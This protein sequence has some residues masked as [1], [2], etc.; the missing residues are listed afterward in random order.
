MVQLR[1][2]RYRRADQSR[3][4]SRFELNDHYGL[5]QQVLNLDF[6]PQT[7]WM[8]VGFWKNNPRSLPQACQALLEEVLRE[9][10]LDARSDDQHF[11]VLEVGCGCAEP[12]RFLRQEFPA[13]FD[14]YIG[15]TLNACQADYAAKR[16]AADSQKS[17]TDG[18]AHQNHIYCADAANPSSWPEGLRNDLDQMLLS[19]HQKSGSTLWLLALDTLY[20]FAPDRKQILTY[21]CQDMGASLMATD[22]IVPDGLSWLESMKLRL[23]FW[24]LQVPWKNVMTYDEYLRMLVECGYRED[25]ITMTDITEYCFDGFDKFTAEHM[26]RWEAMGGSSVIPRAVRMMGRLMGWWASSGVV[27]EY[28]IVAKNV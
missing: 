24:G 8:N 12:A 20:H 17:P 22:I 14:A 10:G 25:N 28:I 3:G 13:T 26:E 5:E 19:S 4:L 1:K 2:K 11:S 7:M 23:V 27:R 21:A 9:A 6:E 15:I 18:H 16:L